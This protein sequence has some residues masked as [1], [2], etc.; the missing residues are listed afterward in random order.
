MTTELI[1]NYVRS[2]TRTVLLHIIDNTLPAMSPFF[3]VRTNTRP[4]CC[5]KSCIFVTEAE[6]VE[7]PKHS[8]LGMQQTT[9]SAVLLSS[10]RRE[11][12]F[13]L[14]PIYRLRSDHESPA[15]GRWF[16]TPH[17]QNLYRDAG[18]KVVAADD[19][20]AQTVQ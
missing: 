19:Q 2:S 13:Y 20:D 16:V 9:K 10:L 3:T 18:G 11:V 15:P 4:C 12:Y 1:N 14:Y 5:E 17:H 8:S 7:V 6:K